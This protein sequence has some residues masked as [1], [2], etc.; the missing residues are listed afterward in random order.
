MVL[1]PAVCAFFRHAEP[2]SLSR[3]TISRT[4][5]PEL[6]MLSQIVPNFDLSP[7]AFWMSDCRPA[8]SNAALSS[9]RS[10]DSQRGE[11]E[12]SGRITPTFPLELPL[13]PPP[14]PL[15][16]PLLSPPQAASRSAVAAS[17]AAAIV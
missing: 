9:G 14:E 2:E 13:P 6:I 11:V 10:L 16:E 7:F 15:L 5:T 12:A 4:F 17:A 3:L 1:M 8:L